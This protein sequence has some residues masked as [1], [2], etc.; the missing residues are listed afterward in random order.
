MKKTTLALGLC[1]ALATTAGAQKQGG[2]SAS[3]LQ[4]IEKSQGS[5]ATNKALFNAVASNRIDNLAKNFSNRNTFDTHFS[6]ETTKQSIHDQKS[7][8]RCW[9][10]SSFNVFRA[11]FARH[12]ADSLSVEFSHDYLFFYDQLEKANLM[13]QG[14]IDNAKKPMDDVR[15]QFFFKNPLNDGGTFCGAADLAPKYGLVPK[16]V[17]P[18]TFSAENTSK[19]S[20]LISSKLREYGLEL[21]KMVANGKK[22]QAIDARKT[23]ML[24]TVYRM[25]AM[26]LGEPVKEFT[27]QFR[28]RCGEPVGEPRRYT[29]L[30][31]YNETVGHQLAGTFIMVMNDPRR[32]YHRTYE[33]EYDR[34]VYDGTNWKY[35]NLPMEDIAKLA[36]ASLKDGKK[37]YSS[38][39]VGK[40]FDRELGYLDTEN[41]DYASLF[42][43][44]F[45]MNKADRIAT[46]DS[47]STHA[48]TLVA[49]DLDKDGNPLKW[50]V[51]NSWG[52]NNGAQGC[53]I[54]SNRW[55]NEYMFRLVVDKK[56]VP[57]NL[58]KEFEQKPVMVMPE[59][60]LFGEDD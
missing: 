5:T 26:A 7:S 36:I 8:G 40:Q 15:V 53:L 22:A 31:F 29:P 28:N 52:P 34:H 43:T 12:H 11:D 30:E 37:V 60:P 14:V 58:Q 4:Q 23:E 3:M 47:G 49:V 51:E 25:L 38:Y 42:S 9:M 20:S 54:M 24:S 16:S 41:F 57:E 44:T 46:F 50:K 18:E 56:Y 10:F 59:D 17:Q 6:V 27:Y 19:I 45:P 55:F 21:R 1:L 2:I 48:M 35:L 13:L 32:P 39:D 33:V